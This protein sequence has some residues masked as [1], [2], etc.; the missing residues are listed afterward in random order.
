MSGLHDLL[1]R[2]AERFPDKAAFVDATGAATTYAQLDG[3]SAALAAALRRAGVAKGDRVMILIDGHVDYLIAFY[4]ALKAGAVA[5]P[6]CPDT[7]AA[8]LARALRHS[9]A[10]AVVLDSANLRYLDEEPELPT[11]L[12][13]AAV[14][15]KPGH[16]LARQVTVADF[17][18]LSS[19]NDVVHDGGVAREDLAA[20]VY[21]SGTT[22]E[23]KGVMLPHRALL[24]NTASI[25]EYFALGPAEIAGMVLPFYYVFGNSVLHTHLAVGATIAHLGSMTFMGQVLKLLSERHCTSLSGVPSTFARLLAADLTGFDLSRLRYLA[26]AG[27]AMPPAHVERLRAA[28]PHVSVYVMYGQTEASARLAYVPPDM[29]ATKVGSAGRAIPGVTLKVVDSEGRQLGLRQVGE[30][31]AQGENVMLGYWRDPEATARVLKPDGLH[32]GDFGFMDADGYIFLKGRA[33]ELIKSGGHRISPLEIEAAVL[34][35]PGVH[36]CAVAGIPDE[37]L[38]ETIVAFIVKRPGEDLTKRKILDVCFAS[39]PRFKMPS[40]LRI[41]DA[42][43]KNDAGKIQ[44]V[45]LRQWYAE[46]RVTVL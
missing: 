29:L 45:I 9:E 36:E 46:G 24:A 7:R 20:I 25:I 23:P 5:V 22:G 27:A 10:R 43:P 28:L 21:T 13:L 4:G 14:R 41:V 37:L 18:E 16:A 42:L 2:S 1:R 26:Q 8:P 38:G 3:R 34:E 39:L 19:G 6:L 40:E 44:R 33:S 17:V 32:T 15:G 35:A 30:I 12:R 11:E 31:V